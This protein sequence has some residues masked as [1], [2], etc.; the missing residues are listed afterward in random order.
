MRMNASGYVREE[1]RAVTDERLRLTAFVKC[2][3]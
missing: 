3:G 1:V 2:P